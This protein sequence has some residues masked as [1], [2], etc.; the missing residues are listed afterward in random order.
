MRTVQ[1]GTLLP[2]G[3]FLL[4][5]NSAMSFDMAFWED[6]AATQPSDL[7]GAVIT[8]EI[9][10]GSSVV[11]FTAANVGNRGVWS[12]TSVQTNVA[13]ERATFVVVFTKSGDRNSILSGLVRV[14]S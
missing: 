2:S 9:D 7:T 12:L 11:T 4:K 1:I 14:Q 6:E 8:M 3:E 10:T 13:W 5:K